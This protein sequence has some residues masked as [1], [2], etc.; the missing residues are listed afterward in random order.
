M[1]LSRVLSDTRSNDQQPIAPRIVAYTA[2]R[3]KLRAALTMLRFDRLDG[4]NGFHPS[5]HSHLR[6]QSKHRPGFTIRAMLGTRLVGDA[7][8][9]TPP[10]DPSCRRVE[11]ALCDGPHLSVAVNVHLAADRAG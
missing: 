2:T 6:A 5:A 1:R 8:T 9:P 11:G 10:S 4:F 7:L 3:P